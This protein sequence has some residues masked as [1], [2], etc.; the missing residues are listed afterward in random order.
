[1]CESAH[2]SAP[3]PATAPAA[4]VPADLDVT[5]GPP[6]HFDHPTGLDG[7]ARHL[8]RANPPVIIPPD[9]W[10]RR[11]MIIPGRDPIEMP[12]TSK[13]A[14]VDA[15]FEIVERPEPSFLLESS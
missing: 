12:T 8:G 11:R 4:W 10:S 5:L 3:V 14:M 7:L 13:R 2:E 1:M 6:G 9:F 15:G